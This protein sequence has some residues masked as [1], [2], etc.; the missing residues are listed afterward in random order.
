MRHRD[1]DYVGEP[2]SLARVRTKNQVTNN[3]AVYSKEFAID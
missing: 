2:F 1:K 3:N